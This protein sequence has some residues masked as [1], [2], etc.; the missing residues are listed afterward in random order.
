MVI[1][2]RTASFD[3]QTVTADTLG[4]TI[5]TLI[6]GVRGAGNTLY[7]CVAVSAM[8]AASGNETYAV[9]LQHGTAVSGGNVQT[10]VDIAGTTLTFDRSKTNEFKWVAIQGTESINRYV[11]AAANPGGTTPSFK[12]TAWV[13]GIRPESD[14]KYA[15]AISFIDAA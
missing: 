7:F 10:P 3:D 4:N 8:D 12:V 14:T 1:D 11:A 15:D 9:K 13:T 6:A 2:K 5:D